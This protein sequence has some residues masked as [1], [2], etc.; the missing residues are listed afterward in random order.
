MSPKYKFHGMH[1]RLRGPSNLLILHQIIKIEPD[2]PS[3]AAFTVSDKSINIRLA[4][5]S[6][7]KLECPPPTFILNINVKLWF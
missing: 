3:L 5:S 4:K 6:Y 1:A 7:N 2:F